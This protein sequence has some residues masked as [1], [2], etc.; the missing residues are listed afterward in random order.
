M[1]MS[2]Q[3]KNNSTA[4]EALQPG[5]GG[6]D[7]CSEQAA[8]DEIELDETDNH[9][10]QITEPRDLFFFFKYTRALD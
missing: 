6:V 2:R 3:K 4:E 1:A 7:E 9:T 5:G 8:P 10:T